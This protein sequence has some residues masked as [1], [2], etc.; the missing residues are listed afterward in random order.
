MLQDAV[1]VIEFQSTP[2]CNGIN[3]AILRR[4][5]KRAVAAVR[6]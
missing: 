6:R 4:E 5:L 2:G 3:A 1:E